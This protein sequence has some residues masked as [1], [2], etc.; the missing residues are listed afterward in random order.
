MY[1]LRHE[2]MEC[3]CLTGALLLSAGTKGEKEISPIRDTLG[4]KGLSICES[5]SVSFI[6]FIKDN[7]GRLNI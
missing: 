6:Y 3:S 2:I 1:M 5:V 4:I 7:L